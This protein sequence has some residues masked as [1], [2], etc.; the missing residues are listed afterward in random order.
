MIIILPS[1]N[2][3]T[4]GNA[5]TSFSILS[6]SMSTGTFIVVRT[7]PLICTAIS[8]ESTASA[9]SSTFGHAAACT[10]TSSA[11]IP[12][13]SSYVICGTKGASRINKSRSSSF[14]K[15]SS[16]VLCFS[17]NL[18]ISFTSSIIALIAVLKANFPSKSSVTLAID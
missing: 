14:A 17:P 8:N 13:Q 6:L 11:P 1:V 9:A 12:C 2:F 3:C 4:S 15:L 7:L 16:I 10:L 5:L 18:Y